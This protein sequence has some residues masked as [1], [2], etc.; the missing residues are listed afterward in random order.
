MRRFGFLSEG[1]VATPSPLVCQRRFASS[2]PKVPPRNISL[3]R[4][5]RP[6]VSAVSVFLYGIHINS[7]PALIPPQPN[8]SDPMK[9]M[10]HR[11]VRMGR[12]PEYE[13]LRTTTKDSDDESSRGRRRLG[14]WRPEVPAGHVPVLV[15]EEM[16]RFAVPAEM[17]GRPLF[18]EL[19]RRS[20]EEY[21]YGQSGVLRIPCTVPLFCRVLRFLSV[22]AYSDPTDENESEIL[23]SFD[24]NTRS[25]TDGK[26]T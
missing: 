7:Y 5:F 1:I 12:A 23:Q 26:P 9:Q 8:S 6:F 25:I 3:L 13:P 2:C 14:R 10:I 19:L 15:G 17:L 24:H 16:E 22:V 4:W 21:G 18:H 20:A 11:L